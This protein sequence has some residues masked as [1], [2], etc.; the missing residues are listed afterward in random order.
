MSGL[1]AF[2][3]E[4]VVA[5]VRD[6][7]GDPAELRRVLDRYPFQAAAKFVL[8]RRGVPIREDVRPPLRRLTDR[9]RRELDE[10]LESS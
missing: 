1:A 5:L 4:R 3:P 8:G 6:R 10:W 9:E 2:F 7:E